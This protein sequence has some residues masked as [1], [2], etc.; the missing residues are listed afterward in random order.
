MSSREILEE[1][2]KLNRDQRKEIIQRALELNW[3]Q[4]DRE[5]IAICEAIALESFQMMDRLVPT[6]AGKHHIHSQV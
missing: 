4:A 1:L 5:E 3:D 6:T 2:P